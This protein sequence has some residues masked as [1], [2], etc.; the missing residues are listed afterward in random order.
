M[1]VEKRLALKEELAEAVTPEDWEWH[2]EFSRLELEIP[3]TVKR[4]V[5][6]LMATRACSND[7]ALNN[8][9]INYLCLYSL[10]DYLAK[11]P[12]LR[13]KQL[14]V[15][16]EEGELVEL[17]EFF[18]GVKV[19]FNER[20]LV[21]L[22]MEV[23]ELEVLEIPQEWVDITEFTAEYYIAIQ[24]DPENDRIAFVGGSSYQTIK[25]RGVYDAGLRAYCLAVENLC[26]FNTVL[27]TEPAAKPVI[28]PLPKLSLERSQCLL[29]QLSK[30]TLCSPRFLAPFSQY[31][32]L[33][34]DPEL[35]KQLYRRRTQ[36]LPV[37]V[38]LWLEGKVD[39]IARALAWELVSLPTMA[40]ALRSG[41][42]SEL[43]RILKSLNESNISIPLEAKCASL[44]SRELA[45]APQVYTIVW[46]VRD[47]TPEEWA[48][49]VILKA[50]SGSTLPV[51]TKLQIRDE[52]QLLVDYEMTPDRF[53]QQVSANTFLY[54][55][56][57]GTTDERF[58]VTVDLTNGL[59]L[60][61]P[62]LA[63]NP[64]VE[65]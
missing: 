20:Q 18:N 63:F 21:L 5:D 14:T 61:L 59:T 2:T 30:P 43:E 31:G 47:V 17:L 62:P 9:R 33:L 64:E 10:V 7:I 23:D 52:M 53:R 65:R 1:S 60:D 58:R 57:C 27:V 44:P 54:G 6:G 46:P 50:R 36:K 39:E 34:A 29:A 56:V 25:Q 35:R 19:A 38:G 16:P 41:T 40:M 37:N 15:F 42:T 48:L 45:V 22:P 13:D 28:E 24:V 26:G 55:Q 4:K 11:E 12:D 3:A 32:A 49:L 8:A 51:G